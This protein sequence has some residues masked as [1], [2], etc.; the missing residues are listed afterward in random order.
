M[1]GAPGSCRPLAHVT[2]CLEVEGPQLLLHESARGCLRLACFSSYSG[3]TLVVVTVG[4]GGVV[5]VL[6]KGAAARPNPGD[7]KVNK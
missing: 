4:G 2:K 6:S 7:W 5:C 1:N 3:K